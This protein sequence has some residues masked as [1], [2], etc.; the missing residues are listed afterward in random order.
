MNNEHYMAH[1]QYLR[2]IE[3]TASVCREGHHAFA[4]TLE[5]M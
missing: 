5:N 3:G 2:R 4:S 1:W